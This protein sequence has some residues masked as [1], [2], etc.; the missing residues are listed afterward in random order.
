MPD[1]EALR[2]EAETLIAE[3]PD[4]HVMRSCWNCNPAHEHLQDRDTVLI[5]CYSCGHH[6]YK[7]H[8]LVVE[9]PECEDAGDEDWIEVHA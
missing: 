3:D 5:T 9:C 7:G 2:R 4:K 6:Y 8:D 1:I